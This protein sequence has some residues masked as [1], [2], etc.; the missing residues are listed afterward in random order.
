[1][2]VS[3]KNRGNIDWIAVDWGTSTLRVQAMDHHGEVLASAHSDN[4]MGKLGADDFEPAL[5]RLIAD[6][7]PESTARP[8]P[9]LICGMA[10]ARQGWREAAYRFLPC[11][12]VS[13][14]MLTEVAT[15]EARIHV[16]IIPGLAQADPADV[17]RGEETQIAGLLARGTCDA[18]VCLPG[19][20][21][22]WVRLKAGEVV[23]F[24][25]VMTGEL[26]SL[27]SQYSILRYSVDAALKPAGTSAFLEAVDQMIRTPA[28][29][30]AALFSIRARD[31]LGKD[32]EAGAALSGLLI[33][34]ELA[35]QI[36]NW[37]GQTVH[38]VGDA[39]LVSLYAKALAHVGAEPVIEDGSALAL[40]G[41]CQVRNQISEITP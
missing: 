23:E 31:L 25:T 18:T 8:L 24:S 1:M 26:F 38:L 3:S 36:A 9:V 5:L 29:L 10:G 2:N 15:S 40:A 16:Q 34:A 12:P 30:T 14:D 21:C 20:H 28:E 22:K 4:G 39:A 37:Q 17:M 41:L 27:V 7:L 11:A 35:G 13:G 32:Q 19:T 6:W 33:G